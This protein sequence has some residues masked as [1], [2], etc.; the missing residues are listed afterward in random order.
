[1]E[2]GGDVKD[3]L[4]GLAC[5]TLVLVMGLFLYIKVGLAEI[6]A[7]VAPGPFTSRFLDSSVHA[8]VRRSAAVRQ[9][10]PQV[11]EQTLIAGG[12]LYFNDCVGCHGE[13][14]KPAS[15]FGASFYPPAPQLTQTPT[16]YTEAEIFWIAKHGIRRTGMG[17]QSDSYSDAD[18]WR[19]ASFIYQ[20]P[21][22]TPRVMGA[23][24]QPSTPHATDK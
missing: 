21:K 14:G 16:R 15:A 8:A 17:S 20:I 23:I 9:D 6:R 3:F 13:P 19:L 11:D 22:L 12:K 1:V 10:P 5:G 4:K 7:D 24:Q 2:R 18:L